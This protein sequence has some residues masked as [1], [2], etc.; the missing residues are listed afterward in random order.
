MNNR[1]FCILGFVMLITVSY[2][3]LARADITPSTFLQ[4]ALDTNL[5][6]SGQENMTLPFRVSRAFSRMRE[7]GIKPL[8]YICVE[9][10]SDKALPNIS[11][12]LPEGTLR[13]QLDRLCKAANYEW[14]ASGDWVNL[15]PKGKLNDPN[16]IM[17]QRLSGTFTL[18][19][20]PGMYTSVK[21]WFAA[22]KILSARDMHAFHLTNAKR[23]YGPDPITLVNPTLRE[24]CNA[25]EAMYGNYLT[26][27]GIKTVTWNGA[28]YTEMIEWGQCDWVFEPDPISQTTPAMKTESKQ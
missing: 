18:T 8:P 11:E 6:A 19:R 21:E 10:E 24:H 28:S 25:H 4:A 26:T 9:Y 22:H 27:I 2:G 15:V 1:A 23:K 12:E 14:Q 3:S 7:Q 16:Y 5:P 13:E 20:A 17:N